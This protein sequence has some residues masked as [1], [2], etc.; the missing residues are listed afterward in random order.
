MRV[1]ELAT[2]FALMALSAIFMAYGLALP[3]GWERGVGRGDAAPSFG[4][5]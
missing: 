3:I 2:A 5:P 1:A 4:G